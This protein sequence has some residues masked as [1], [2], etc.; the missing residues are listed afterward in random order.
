MK[1]HA[2]F[3]RCTSRGAGI[4]RGTPKSGALWHCPLG[5]RGGRFSEEKTVGKSAPFSVFLLSCF[6]S[7][8]AYKPRYFTA[9]QYVVIGAVC[10]GRMV[11]VGYIHT[12]I[13]LKFDSA[14][15]TKVKSSDALQ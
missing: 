7:V 3:G 10:G 14:A 2:E 6:D 8:V 11:F 13:Q 4:S 1:C 9:A 5:M 15:L 12:Y